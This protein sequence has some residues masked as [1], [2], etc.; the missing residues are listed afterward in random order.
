MGFRHFLSA[1]AVAF[2]HSAHAAVSSTGF[3][4]SLTDIP[5]FLPPQ[6]IATLPV[7]DSLKTAFSNGPFLPFTVM[8]STTEISAVTI[9]YLAEDDVFQTG[10]LEGTSLTGY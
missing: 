3:T 4:V 8:K 5:Y 9:Q 1:T 2:I 7:T 6:S 10:F